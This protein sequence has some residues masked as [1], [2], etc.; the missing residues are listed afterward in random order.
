[1]MIEITIP[2]KAETKGRP[3]V[4]VR[5]G[6]PVVYKPKEQTSFEN[7]IKHRAKEK[8]DKPFDG[9]VSLMI[10]FF[11][12]RPK[13]I[14]WKTKPMPLVFSDK[15]PDLSNLTKCVEDGLTGIAYHDDSQIAVLHVTK[16]YHAKENAYFKPEDGSPVQPLTKITVSELK[17]YI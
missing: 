3:S 14:I 10:S 2:G 8:I 7:L 12:H 9:P 17:N 5:N 16:H 6:K 11:L 13:R 4:F 15:K 1:M